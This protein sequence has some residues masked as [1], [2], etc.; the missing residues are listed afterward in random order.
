[1]GRREP[2]GCAHVHANEAMDGK[3][4]QKAQDL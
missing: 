3:D 4:A 1:M 2:G